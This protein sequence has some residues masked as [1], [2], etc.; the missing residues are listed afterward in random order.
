MQ[1]SGVVPVETASAGNRTV[2]KINAK[3]GASKGMARSDAGIWWPEV[4][5][6]ASPVLPPFDGSGETRI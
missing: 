5:P 4:N 3:Q 1:Q 2:R 6:D